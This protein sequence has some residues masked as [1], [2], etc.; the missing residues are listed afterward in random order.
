MNRSERR[1]FE[2][3]AKAQRAKATTATPMYDLVQYRKNIKDVFDMEKTAGKTLTHYEYH[4]GEQALNALDTSGEVNAQIANYAAAGMRLYK[5][6]PVDEKT[7]R[8]TGCVS[9][10]IKVYRKDGVVFWDYSNPDIMSVA[11]GYAPARCEVAMI[12]VVLQ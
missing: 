1:K 5:E 9:A 10:T 4:F 8:E 11:F 2:R 12:E 3:Q 7:C 6:I